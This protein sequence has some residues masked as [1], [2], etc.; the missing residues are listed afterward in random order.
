MYTLST[1]TGEILEI[2]LETQSVKAH[3][4]V[5]SHS[6]FLR[7]LD[8]VGDK[9]IIG[10]SVN[11]KTNDKDKQCYII[12]ADLKDKTHARYDLDGIKFINDLKVA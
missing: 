12:I 3:K 1:A 11:F 2:N 9:L 7:G 4:L 6:T 10:C 5:D 8:I